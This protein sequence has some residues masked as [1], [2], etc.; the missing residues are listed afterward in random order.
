MSGL[1]KSSVSASGLP[2]FLSN[3]LNNSNQYRNHLK[4]RNN[5]PILETDPRLDALLA[6]IQNSNHSKSI[7]SNLEIPNSTD[8]SLECN[9]VQNLLIVKKNDELIKCKTATSV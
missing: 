4:L 8:S 3:M 5:L 9:N 6:S 2:S 1:K 7:K